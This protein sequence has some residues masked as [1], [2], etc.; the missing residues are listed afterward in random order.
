[1]LDAP[2]PPLVSVSPARDRAILAEPIRYPGVAELARPMLRLA[3]L[4]ISPAN[5]A[6]HTGPRLQNLR[7]KSIA[8]GKEVPITSP[9]DARL[10][11]PVW[12][13]DGKM[14]FFTATADR[15]VQLWV[16]NA[17][18]GAARQIPAVRLNTVVGPGCTWMPDAKKLLCWTVPALRGKAPEKNPAPSGPNVQESYGRAADLRTFQD[19]LQNP[20]DEAI[21]EYY[22]ATQLALVDT[23]TGRVTSIGKPD[24]I[25]TAD[26]APDGK[27]LRI[28]RT[29]KPYSYI[30]TI[31]AFPEEIEVWDTAG[32]LVHKVAS[33]P[34]QDNLPNGGVQTGPRNVNWRPTDPA[35]LVWVE[36]LDGG[37]PKNKVAHRDKVMW[38]KAPFKDPPAELLKTEHRYAGI[39]WGEAGNLAILREFDRDK[40]WSRTW[41]LNPN[42]PEA[43]PRLVWEMSINERY[44][45]PGTPS[46]RRLPSGHFAVRQHGEHIFLAG[47][48]ATPEGDRPFLDRFST[49]TL[50]A[51]RLF[52]SG[53]KGYEAVSAILSDDGSKFLTRYESPTEPPNFYLRTAGS[54]ARQAFTS[55]SDPHPQLQQIKKQLVKYK[56]ADGVDLSFT[57]YLPPDYKPGERRPAVV[58]AYPLEYTDPGVAGQV[59]ASPNRFNTFTGIS[60]LFFALAGYVVLDDATMP[61]VGNPETVNNTYVEQ[62][63]S[64]ARACIDMAAEL[65]FVDPTRVGVGGHSYGAFMTAN[66]LAHSDLFR[67]GIARSGAYNRTLTPF[68]FQSERR[69]IWQATEMYIKISPFM[70][71][72]KIKEPVLLIHGE[73]DNNSGTFPIQSERM[74][75]AIRGNGGNVRYVTL[76]H[77]SHGYAAR[78][79]V[80]HTLWEM[81]N[82]FEKH[83]KN[84][85]SQQRAA[86]QP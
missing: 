10:N 21:F 43:A 48:G 57:M 56:R 35:T 18:T 65:G 8:D 27:H 82:W 39:Q 31:F 66:L 77:E 9:A 76:P 49:S 29:H 41:F 17:S 64:S 70:H 24:L 25:V 2:A 7:I 5:N 85:E 53:E 44:K 23:G 62:I 83:V 84:A 50:Q 1:V 26:P 33:I 20:Y 79:S 78:E 86:S 81:L 52:R 72:H 46:T 37:D 51:E 36:A 71:A 75:Q 54:D 28:H 42:H 14:F 69:T 38:Q 22:L 32:K 55:Y 40:N 68:G 45:N 59:S 60:H 12:S 58:W 4:R 63:V 3:G 16:G 19:L 13:P 80:E 11:L 6:P 47:A 34:I 67:A 15:T 73:A 74:Y 61:V 30:L